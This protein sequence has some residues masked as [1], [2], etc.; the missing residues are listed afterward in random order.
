MPNSFLIAV[1]RFQG[2]AFIEIYLFAF[3]LATSR[4]TTL[5]ATI[6][7]THQGHLSRYHYKEANSWRVQLAREISYMHARK[8]Y[9]VA[10]ILIPQIACVQKICVNVQV[11][12]C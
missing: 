4:C 3:D 6:P 7:C 9:V 2:D 12:M 5:K 1:Q 11:H 8:Q 10:K